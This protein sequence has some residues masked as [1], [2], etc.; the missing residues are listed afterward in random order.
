ML[1]LVSVAG[2]IKEVVFT[3]PTV[4]VVCKTEVPVRTLVVLEDTR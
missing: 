1:K 3:T 4:D 2:T